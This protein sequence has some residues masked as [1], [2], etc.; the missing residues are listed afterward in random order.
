MSLEIFKY[1]FIFINIVTFIDFGLDKYNA[2]K[3]SWRIRESSLF[4][5]SIFGRLN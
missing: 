3:N 5:L 2:I 1:Y 4:I